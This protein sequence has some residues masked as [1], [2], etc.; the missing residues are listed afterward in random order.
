[1]K[2]QDLEKQWKELIP[3]VYHWT[4]DI[5]PAFSESLIPDGMNII[6]M[7]ED[8]E[9]PGKLKVKSLLPEE[10]ICKLES[11][12][13]AAGWKGTSLMEKVDGISVLFVMVSEVNA[14]PAQKG[15]QLGLEA[16]KALKGFRVSH[17]AF[18]GN[19]EIGSLDMFEGFCNGLYDEGIF[20]KRD[21]PREES[22]LPGN[23][24]FI[25]P[26]E[27]AGAFEEKRAL[28]RALVFTRFL[29]DIPSNMLTPQVF[30]KLAKAV[31]SELGISCTLNGKKELEAFG[32]GSY[33]SVSQGSEND[34]CF[35]VIEIPGADA[36]RTA[37]LAGK[38]LT[39]DTGGISIKPS[40]GMEE[41][42]YDMSGG[43]CVLGSAIYLAALEEQPPVNVVCLI[44]AAENMPS[45]RA[46]KPGD[47]VRAMNG[48]TIEVLNTDAE[49]RLVLA[50]L[51]SYA[52]EKYDPEFVIDAAT[53]TGGVI[54]ALGH[55]G[56]G[57]MGNNQEFTDYL[58]EISQVCGEPVWQLPLWPELEQEVKGTFADL[59]NIPKPNV[60]ASSVMG[61]WFLAQFIG[62]VPWVHVDIAG[63]A[64][65]CTAVG[66][67]ANQSSAFG[68]RLL[69]DACRFYSPKN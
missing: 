20:K 40:R 25:G 5:V 12:I 27:L 13:N 52:Q 37:V 43:A 62:K 39:F 60:L 53:L 50:D 2:K 38:G 28:I 41:M 64:W 54:A 18:S 3:E 55:A 10:T 8:P 67:P 16:V 17:I 68:V 63:T 21:V 45:G 65:S 9:N 11:C 14:A 34:P 66:Y 56:A 19:K 51:L 61:G 7:A 31:S 32:M 47:I 46:S 59:R 48:K 36:S 33:L 49:G 30:G 29:Q 24:S 6:P 69:S 57:I 58:K 15:R 1:M 23:I 22:S 42:K 4:D 26:G 44:G 35:I